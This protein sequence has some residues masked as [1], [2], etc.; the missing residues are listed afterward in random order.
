MPT[1]EHV[2]GVGNR[3]YRPALANAHVIVLGAVTK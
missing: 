1:D 2:F 3:W